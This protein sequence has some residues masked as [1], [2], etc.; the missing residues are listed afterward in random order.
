MR[1]FRRISQALFLLLFLFLVFATRYGGTDQISYPVR[2]FLDF[3]PLIFLSTLFAAHAFPLALLS[4]LVVILITALL[5]RVFCGW[6]CPL[7][8]LH[9]LMSCLR[10]RT[11]RNQE[12][13]RLW[14]W[15]PL[16]YY[17]LV[18][19]LVSSL[20]T[21]QL[22]GFFD[23][24]SLLIRSFALFIDPAV[25][26]IFHPFLQLLSSS[27]LPILNGLSESLRNWGQ[28]T[29]L[30]FEPPHFYQ[31]TIIG[32][33]FLG[34]L[35]LNLLGSR[36]WC[37]AICPLGALLGL[38]SRTGLARLKI[39]DHC[40]GCEVC[41]RTCQTA[42]SPYPASSWKSA[43]CIYCWNCRD[44]CPVGAAQFQF[45]GM[46][47]PPSG[48]NLDRRILLGSAIGGLLSLPLFRIGPFAM[49]P[50]PRLIRPPGARPETDFL[51]RCIRCGECM[52]VCPT[53]GLQPAL[54]QG[55]AEGLWS[56]ILI[57]RIGY[58]EFSC[59]LCGQ[60][61]PT[62]A[63]ERLI[64]QR[65]QKVRI[66]LA[67]VDRNRCLPYAQGIQ[68]IVCEEHCP[69]PKKAIWLQEGQ[70][71]DRGGK[72]RRV[73]LPQVDLD[74][75]IGCGI[76]EKRCPILDLPAIRVSS[77]GEL[78]NPNNQLILSSASLAAKDRD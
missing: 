44:L 48:L 70:I 10:K 63:I 57:P 68:C 27:G 1:K 46:A 15:Q 42:A 8:T 3:D 22:V 64:L 16:K 37:V 4:S 41:N 61:C 11:G 34:I 74:L 13:E 66:G 53:H 23:P 47:R 72:F 20:F 58:C 2:V 30:S 43:E 77:I 21:L 75:C 19:L 39:N 65:K 52:K 45:L 18:F 32:I 28:Q 69:T 78:R 36:F 76:C 51:R 59:T 49:A 6:I 5:G 55:G 50:S 31:A 24:M 9:N 38:L 35:T 40:N 25:N 67:F 29:F 54:L 26:L 56:P 33:V 14:R 7:G 62:G 71:K 12:G 73:K 17:L 60:V